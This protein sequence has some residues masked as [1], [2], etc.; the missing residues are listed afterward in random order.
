[1]QSLLQNSE[2]YVNYLL[3]TMYF[4]SYCEKCVCDLSAT[5]KVWRDLLGLLI[6]GFE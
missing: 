6:S 3:P 1:M 5:I 2:L 4:Y